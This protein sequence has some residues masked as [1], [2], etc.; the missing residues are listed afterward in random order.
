MAPFL[1]IL[2]FAA[3]M[4]S[5]TNKFFSLK[6][7]PVKRGYQPDA[8][9][10]AEQCF[11]CPEEAEP[12]NRG[13]GA[14]LPDNMA[15]APQRPMYGGGRPYGQPMPP[16]APMQFRQPNNI[17]RPQYNFW[18][19]GQRPGP[20]S[21]QMPTNSPFG[22][23]SQQQPHFDGMV[24]N[25][26]SFASDVMPAHDF[27]NGNNPWCPEA[28]NFDD[29]GV[30]GVSDDFCPQTGRRRPP[31]MARSSISVGNIRRP[32][33]KEVCSGPSGLVVVRL[34]SKSSEVGLV[35]ASISAVPAMVNAK[36]EGDVAA[37]I[38]KCAHDT[39]R[40][41][42]G[43]WF[44]ESDRPCPVISPKRGQVRKSRKMTVA[45]VLCQT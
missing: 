20:F 8:V 1:F 18:P 12:A 35:C 34:L 3:V 33:Q 22:P 25:D 19:Q 16:S 26:P 36:N 44:G 38:R 17:N 6:T 31:V 32:K 11:D 24:G 45:P 10:E 9:E 42:V 43:G 14:P 21:G 2:S 13:Y 5:C 23:V 41:F 27:T 39:E 37:I 40:V 15:F 4:S 28:A 29:G 7:G 30:G